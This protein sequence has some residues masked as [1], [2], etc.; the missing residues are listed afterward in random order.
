MEIYFWLCLSALGAG[1]MNA[2][3]GG[4]TLLTFPALVAVISP[5]AANV[6][7]TLA[8]L[9]GSIASA[10]GYRRE[11]YASRRWI[12]LLTVPSLLG[13]L[14][15]ALLITQ[16]DEAI[17]KA[18]V[19]WLVLLAATFFFLQPTISRLVRREILTHKQ[20]QKL[21]WPTRALLVLAQLFVA[22]YGGYFG[23]GIGILMLTS[24][25]FLDLASIH[26]MNALKTWLAFCINGIS[27]VLFA[28]DGQVVWR[29]ALAMALAAIAGGYFGARLGLRIR[30]L[31]VR[32][33]VIVIGFGLAAY[34]FV[35]Q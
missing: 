25:A 33:I 1:V 19:P 12:L 8:L 2:L 32:W 26:E 17:F 22:I 6:T 11:L 27:A 5:V 20:P 29:Y 28:I 4:G 30:P 14:A 13:G 21:T 3:A 15:G 9:P 7:S 23:A 35:K 16:L 24:L 34:F 18:L 10:W 31:Y